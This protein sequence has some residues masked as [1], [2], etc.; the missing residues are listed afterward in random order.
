MLHSGGAPMYRLKLMIYLTLLVLLFIAAR[1]FLSVTAG[2]GFP[3]ALKDQFSREVKINRE[4]ERIVSGSPGNTEILFALGLQAKI[5]GVT[6]WCNFPEQARQI[7]KIGDITPLNVEKVLDLH[8]DLVVADVLNGKEA[9]TRLAELGVPTFALNANSF[10]EI[11]TSIT[12]IGGITGQ[13]V[14][15]QNLVNHLRHTLDQVRQQGLKLKNHGLKVYIVL[16]WE[17][18]WT[19][20]P[21][22]FL[23]EAV[24][25]AGTENIAHDLPSPWGQINMEL[26]MKRNPDVI[27]TDIPPGKIY[28]NPIWAKIAAV[29]KHQV[30]HI[31]GDQYYRPGP[32]L[33]EALKDLAATLSACR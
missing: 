20:G 9:V 17:P 11:L 26:V 21:G 5:V 15:A 16:G 12:L 7:A 19:A 30:Y 10:S 28:S 4:P 8:P 6:N 27:I 22:S 29:Q 25:L 24:T 18:N 31:V 1:P 32:R 23:D 2:A 13:N 33:I 14:A 3:V